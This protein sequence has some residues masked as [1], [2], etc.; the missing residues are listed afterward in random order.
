MPLPVVVSAAAFAS[1]GRLQLAA[2]LRRH[3][4]LCCIDGPPR[5]LYRVARSEHLVQAR[6][7][8][9]NLGVHSYDAV[10]C[11]RA[12]LGWGGSSRRARCRRLERRRNQP[13]P[14]AL[15]RS[16]SCWTP[17]TSTPRTWLRG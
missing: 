13:F 6:C 4:V 1:L 5:A 12:A 3:L 17:P 10:P 11:S 8:Q 2:G 7:N 16:W 15:Q 14:R 9:R